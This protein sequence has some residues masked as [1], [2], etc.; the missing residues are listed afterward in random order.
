MGIKASPGDRSPALQRYLNVGSA[1]AILVKIHSGACW[2]AGR[3]ERPGG[4]LRTERPV[5]TAQTAPTVRTLTGQIV[6]IP[7]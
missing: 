4:T 1:L 5:A 2:R 6:G 7:A 3:P